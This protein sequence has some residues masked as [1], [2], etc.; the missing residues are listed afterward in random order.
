MNSGKE[1]SLDI[2]ASIPLGEQ[3]L[4]R[5]NVTQTQL[6]Y[7]LQ[8]QGVEGGRL[9]QLLLQHGLLTEHDL[10]ISLAEQRGFE[11]MD[12]NM[13]PAP[14]PQL[15]ALFNRELCLI[16]GFMPLVRVENGVDILLGNGD[17]QAVTEL[18]QRRCGL[19]P[20]F[21]QGEFSQVAQMVRQAYYFTQNPVESLIKREITTLASDTDH[22]RSPEKLLEYV[23]H[24]AVRERAT[25]VHIEPSATSYHL[26]FRIDGVLRPMLALPVSLSRLVVYVKLGAEMDISEQRRPQDGSF[27]TTILDTAFTIRVSTLVSEYGERMVLRL[28]PER[29][30]LARLEHLGF[31]AEDVALLRHVFAKP[32][33][34]V[35]LTG[36]TGCGKTTTLHAALRLQALI[37]RNVLTVEDPIEY[38]LP[39]VCQTQVNRRAGYEFSTALRHFLRHDPDVILVGEVRDSETA[40]ATVTASATGHLVLTTLHVSSV[41]GVVP[42]LMPLGLDPQII[43]DNL[44]AVV[45]QRLVRR[46]CPFCSTSVELSE[47]QRNWLGKHASGQVMRGSGCDRCTHTGYLDRLPV[48]EILNV[49]ES[50]ANAIA[51][52]KSR[53]ALR[54]AALEAGFRPMLEMAKWR[55]GQGQTTFD[56]VSRVVGENPELTST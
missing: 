14:D 10:A 22:A 3:L 56:E 44:I 47:S 11:F 6:D 13:A 52:G 19:R 35:L 39:T 33:G 9:G 34:M 50:L 45:N 2:P 23:L 16:N 49:D 26:L 29:T 40:L 54:Q 42:R 53:T 30:D 36:P 21:V 4:L 7:T 28:L 31:L 51:E 55:I 32:A 38:R 5:G 18:V 17:P 41:F 43:A 12:A 37:E 1:P 46:N 48:Y 15:L 27:Q 25:D 24:L 20:N 8:K